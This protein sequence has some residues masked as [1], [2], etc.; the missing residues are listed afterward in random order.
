M[1]LDM[2]AFRSRET[3]A[4]V[5]F[6]YPADAEQF[7]YWRK[8]PDLHGWMEEL[9]RQKGGAAEIFNCKPVRLDSADLD[10]L[11]AAIRGDDLPETSGF[12]FGESTL[13]D[14][15]GDLVFV[16]LAR[17]AIADGFSVYYDSWW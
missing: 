6:S 2:Y 9:Y 13:E 15:E 14:R 5:D 16:G 12:F 3:V 10:A 4:A 1:G 7:G 8:H 17:Q 11:E